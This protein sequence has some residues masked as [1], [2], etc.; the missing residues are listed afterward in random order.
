MKT[1]PTPKPLY[2]E[3]YDNLIFA[4]KFY[5]SIIALLIATLFLVTFRY[6][7]DTNALEQINERLEIE[8]AQALDS[9]DNCLLHAY[10][11]H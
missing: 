8:K 6:N 1:T 4:R 9:L 10:F 5:L 7:R 3:L 2:E 11:K